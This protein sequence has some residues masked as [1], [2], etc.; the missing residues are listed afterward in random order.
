VGGNLENP[1]GGRRQVEFDAMAFARSF[2]VTRA[3]ELVDQITAHLLRYPIDD[4]TRDYLITVL[5]GTADPADW[6][7]DY[8]GAETQVKQF[9]VELMRLPEFQLT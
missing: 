3:I 1:G 9:L 8:P 7:L 2:G 5:V 6:S 4:A